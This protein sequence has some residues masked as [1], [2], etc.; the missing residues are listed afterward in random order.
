M[1]GPPE[2][3]GLQTALK[4]WNT[5]LTGSALPDEGALTDRAKE[6]NDKLS[7]CA[8]AHERLM[9]S[10]GKEAV[11]FVKYELLATMRAIGEKVAAH[12]SVT[13]GSVAVRF[14]A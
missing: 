6:C 12:G 11:P 5:L 9:T 2:L 13:G 10:G 4:D 3:E 14:H 1:I 8:R 7:S